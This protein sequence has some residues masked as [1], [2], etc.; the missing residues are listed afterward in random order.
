[1]HITSYG[2]S[3][4]LIE[5]KGGTI[6]LDPLISGNPLSAGK[7]DI[8]QIKTNAV[9]VSHGHG[10]HIG[11]AAAIAT[12]NEAPIVTN[13]EIA[14]WFEK[15]GV[16]KT[17]GLN[18]GGTTDLGFATV[19]LVPAWHSSTLPDGS[20][21]GTAGGFVITHDEGTFYFSGDTA[22][23]ME[24][25]LIGDLYKP[26]LAF[27]CMGDHFTM[28]VTDAVHAA[29]L[30]KVK[31]VIGMHYDTWPAI[32]IDHAAAIESFRQAGIDLQLLP[33]NTEA[34]I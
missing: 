26:D 20:A 22:I 32:A 8:A 23:S 12:Q 16:A 1:M 3:A 11:D 21:G 17:I 18:H 7:V 9:L 14:A 30:L 2:H 27:L 13:F 34:T 33:P 25:Q 15:Q 24:M 10:D 31:R 6:L 28:S 29:K 5:L 19:K 4:F